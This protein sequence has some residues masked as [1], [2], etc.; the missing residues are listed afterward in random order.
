MV[1]LSLDLTLPVSS[2]SGSDVNGVKVTGIH[3][4][5]SDIIGTKWPMLGTFR[6]YGFPKSGISPRA[7]LLPSQNTGPTCSE[8]VGWF[9]R[10]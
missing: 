3:M 7:A 1:S 6:T 5:T 8:I 2:Y 4:C 9:F 10:T